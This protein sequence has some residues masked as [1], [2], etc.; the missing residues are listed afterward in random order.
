MKTLKN[1]KN[2]VNGD[3]LPTREHRSTVLSDETLRNINGG[4]AAEGSVSCSPCA[5]DCLD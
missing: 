4:M 3:V 2:K 5:D 1:L